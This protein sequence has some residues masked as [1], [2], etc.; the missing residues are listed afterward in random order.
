MELRTRSIL[1]IFLFAQKKGVPPEQLGR[2]TGIDLEALQREKIELDILQIDHLWQ[3]AIRLTNDP[4]FGLHMGEFFNLTSLDLVGGIIQNSSTIR[5]AIE[6]TCRYIN[7]MTQAFQIQLETKEEKFLIVFIP[8]PA[9][10]EKAALGVYQSLDAAMVFAYQECKAL[11]FDRLRPLHLNIAKPENGTSKEY[12]RIFSCPVDFNTARFELAFDIAYLD[13]SI[14][15][16]DYQL[17]LALTQH[18]DQLL[19]TSKESQGLTKIVK[20][21]LVNQ[22]NEAFPQIGDIAAT[23][24]MSV[25]T[26]QRRLKA[27]GTNFQDLLDHV[28]QD[29]AKYYLTHQ[30]QIK[31]I[32]Y[33]LGYNEPNAFTRSFKRWT[34]MTPGEYQMGISG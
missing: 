31:E 32:A 17:L 33:M 1:N 19:A 30:F 22:S 28:R 8:N 2:L 16:A 9:C 24:N 18:A 5:L 13:K 10:M 25:R 12:E 21:A 7:L 20:E 34:G 4:L 15:A 27:E 29:F 6:N 26:L 3:N 11:V 23:L 14:I